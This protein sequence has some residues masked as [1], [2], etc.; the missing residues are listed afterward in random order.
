LIGPV[1]LHFD[2]AFLGAQHDR[3]FAQ[4]PDHVERTVGHT[5][6]R[7]FLH[8]VSNAALHDRA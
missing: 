4:S 3:L 6:Q 8:V 7:Q 1:D 2:L 5:A